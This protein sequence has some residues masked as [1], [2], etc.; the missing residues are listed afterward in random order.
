[1]SYKWA[2]DIQEIQEY[3]GTHQLLALDI[4]ASSFEKSRNDDKASLD[5][6]QSSITE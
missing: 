6:H 1:M 2:L 5:A 3:I 4:E